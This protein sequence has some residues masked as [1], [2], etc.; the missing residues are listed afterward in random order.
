MRWVKRCLI[1]YCVCAIL[2]SGFIAHRGQTAGHDPAAVI[3]F[4][5]VWPLTLYVLID[6]AIRGPSCSGIFSCPGYWAG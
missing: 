4:G 3:V 1:G 2:M 6:I 5:I